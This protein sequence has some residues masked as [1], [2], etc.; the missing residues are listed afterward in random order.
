MN[1]MIR[2]KLMNRLLMVPIY[3]IPIT[4]RVRFVSPRLPLA[5]L[6]LLL[7]GSQRRLLL[8][9]LLLLLSRQPWLPLRLF[10]ILLH[11]PPLLRTSSSEKITQRYPGSNGC[12]AAYHAAGNGPCVAAAAAAAFAS[13]AVGGVI[14]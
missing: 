12:H 4:T 3:T 8:M 7:S 9:L 13:V 14:C 1:N 11:Q 10:R 6:Y 2:R 5:F